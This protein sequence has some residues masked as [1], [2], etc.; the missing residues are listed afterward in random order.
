MPQVRSEVQD[1]GQVE[2][3]RSAAMMSTGPNM[4]VAAVFR[5][6]LERRT[7]QAT[8]NDENF[9][10]GARDTRREE[11][12]NAIRKKGG[13][14]LHK[15]RP[16]PLG[17][18]T[19]IYTM[20]A[21]KQTRQHAQLTTK[22]NHEKGGLSQPPF[23]STGQRRPRGRL[24]R[25][26]RPSARGLVPRPHHQGGVLQRPLRP[27]VARRVAQQ[28]KRTRPELREHAVDRRR[29]P[30]A[31]ARAE[32]TRPLPGGCALH[33]GPPALRSARCR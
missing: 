31:P 25:R 17:K 18:E 1:N 30:V 13:T 10:P 12:E 5:G 9:R 8:S 15:P 6:K 21:H 20:S 28:M 24:A 29:A 26:P 33:A 11:A 27:Q 14:T 16:P 4:L 22:R 23:D 32:G 3:M 2:I 19:G 7:V